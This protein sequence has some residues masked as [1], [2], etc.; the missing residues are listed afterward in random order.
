MKRKHYSLEQIV[1]VL[2]QAELGMAVGD[3]VRQL[4]ISEQTFYRWKKQYSGM[5]S[6]Q[7]TRWGYRRLHIL[8]KREGWQLGVNQTYRWYCLEQ[9]QLRAWRNKRRK[10]AVTGEQ[11]PAV[12]HPNHA[13]CM[14]FVAD[15]LAD[16]SKFEDRCL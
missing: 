12:T 4:G 2:N 8:L 1:A 3:I 16:G 6:E 10:M 7:A 11:R 13:W 15:Q 14:D 9:L 5:Q